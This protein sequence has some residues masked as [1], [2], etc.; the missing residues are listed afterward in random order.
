[1]QELEITIALSRKRQGFFAD[2]ELKF[3]DQSFVKT[4][5]DLFII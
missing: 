5:I 1:V 2:K 4:V 3:S